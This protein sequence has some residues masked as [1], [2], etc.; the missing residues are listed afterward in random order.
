MWSKEKKAAYHKARYLANREKMQAQNAAWRKA[1]PENARAYSAAYRVAYPEKVRAATAAW[2]ITNAEEIKAKRIK[3]WLANQER[4]RA[5]RIAKYGIDASAYQRML[6]EQN[7][8]CRICG[9]N[10]TVRHAR[11]G[12]RRSLAI[13]HDHKTGAVRGLLC[14]NCNIGIGSFRDNSFLLMKAAAYL[15][16]FVNEKKRQA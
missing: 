1:H 16:S 6:L 11:S 2:R 12:K 4:V 3:W 13:D 7:S 10:E 14:S 15:D 9:Q 8:L 5:K